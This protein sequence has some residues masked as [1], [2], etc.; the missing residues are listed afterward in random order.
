MK[1]FLPILFA[2]L[3]LL[4]A[5]IAFADAGTQAQIVEK[6]VKNKTEKLNTDLKIPQ[7]EGMKNKVTQAK[8]NAEFMKTI[9]QFK[10]EVQR[11]SIEA[12]RFPYEAMTTYFVSYHKNDILSL[13]MELYSYTGGAHGMTMRKSYNINLENGKNLPL[14]D[15]F[16][17]DFD[18][19]NLINKE[20]KRQIDMAPEGNYFRDEFKTIKEDQPY[21]LKEDGIVVYFGLYEIAPYA[22]GFPEFLI[23]YS[24]IEE[25]LSKQLQSLEN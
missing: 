3:L 1:R 22:S 10:N 25:G 18:Y 2:S 16:K 14:N 9:M 15:L 23:P 11:Q 19:Q 21:Y 13:T 20:I 24:M 8:L 17:K 7:I 6:Q 12:E 4:Y 5:T